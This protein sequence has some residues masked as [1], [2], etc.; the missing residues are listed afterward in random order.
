MFHKVAIIFFK[1]TFSVEIKL[2][3][4]HPKAAAAVQLSAAA[5]VTAH[6]DTLF[7]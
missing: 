6:S 7:Y 4:I 1:F 3:Y 2:I 5:P